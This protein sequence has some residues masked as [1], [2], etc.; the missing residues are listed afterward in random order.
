[1]EVSGVE[2]AGG[3]FKRLG[4]MGVGAWG[5]GSAGSG[6]RGWTRCDVRGV[7]RLNYEA[8]R[9][10]GECGSHTDGASACARAPDGSA[11]VVTS[12]D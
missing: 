3:E 5:D 8:L 12:S 7:L 10:V 4:A 11:L 2:V 9:V 1:M 6:G